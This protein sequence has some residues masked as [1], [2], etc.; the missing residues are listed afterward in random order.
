MSV[1][2]ENCKEFGGPS[3][4]LLEECLNIDNGCPAYKESICDFD[5]TY[6]ITN[7]E[8]LLG[9]SDCQIFCAATPNCEFFY[10][11][12]QYCTLYSKRVGHCDVISGPFDPKIDACQDSPITTT[13]EITPSGDDV[14]KLSWELELID[15]D[16][17]LVLFNG[18]DKECEVF[19][20]HPECDGAV[21]NTDHNEVKCYQG[22]RKLL[23]SQWVGKI[24]ND[25][26]GS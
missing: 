16:L 11:D 18:L 15:L 26:T 4:P 1:W 10:H 17:H 9:P 25:S 12:R 2:L 22:R 19:F 14:I 8:D 5:Q 3:S 24:I 13:T 20:N 6:V 7:F 23:Q 21:L